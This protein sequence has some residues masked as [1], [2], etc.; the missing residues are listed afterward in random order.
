[1]ELVASFRQNYIQKT[2]TQLML[3]DTL[4]SYNALLF[5]L[6]ILYRLLSGSSYPFGEFLTALFCTL[7]SCLLTVCLRIQ[8][9]N[10]NKS[11]FGEYIACCFVLYLVS[12]NFLV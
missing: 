7:G 4:A 5:M 10:N 12:I 11:A 6:L 2:P 1:M 3:C 9:Q 8:L